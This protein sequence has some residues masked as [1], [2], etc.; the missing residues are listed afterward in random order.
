MEGS[1]AGLDIAWCLND[2]I[3]KLER[4]AVKNSSAADDA[5]RQAVSQQASG[6]QVA[7][8]HYWA[9]LC[10]RHSKQSNADVTQSL[11]GKPTTIVSPN[12]SVRTAGM[13]MAE[14]R[15]AALIVD[16]DGQLAGIFTFKT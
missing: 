9:T 4:S 16:A 7:L 3:S 2:A 10:R 11:A 12:A 14:K 8:Q 15:K 5:V 6:A 13:L 1:V